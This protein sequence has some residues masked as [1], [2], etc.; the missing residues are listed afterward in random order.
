MSLSHMEPE[1]M[2]KPE[3]TVWASKAWALLSAVRGQ[4]P[5]IQCIT[6]FVSMDLMANTLLSAGASPAMIHSIVEIPDFTPHANALY[7]NVGTLSP[8]WL[9]AMKAAAELACRTGKPWVLDPVASGAS[10]F[11]LRACLE[12]V[13]LKPTVIRGNASEVIA[14]SK[15][16][17]GPTKGVDSSHE[18]TDAVD[19]AKSLS[20]ASGAIVAVSGA[21]D[22]ITD[23]ELVVGAHNGV[24]MMQ[25]I[26]ATGCSV[27]ALIAAFV[28]VDPSHAFEATASALSVFGVAGEMGM[29]MANGPASLRMHLIDSLHGLDEVD[30]L[31]RVNIT[32]FS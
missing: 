21:V 9:P 11:R 13:E 8:D 30:V 16:S 27:T 23:G 18:S 14:L 24:A 2:E 4:S 12:L 29:K 19:A 6:N 10:G 31:S 7:I 17:V 32:G 28:A 3:T 22:I 25:R 15:A 5:L 1:S 26:T 20:K